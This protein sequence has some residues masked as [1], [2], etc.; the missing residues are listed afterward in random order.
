MTEQ[1]F[2]IAMVHFKEVQNTGRALEKIYGN[3]ME[4]VTV[5]KTDSTFSTFFLQ[6]F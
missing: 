5:F 3:Y 2:F 6:D 4:N 1:G